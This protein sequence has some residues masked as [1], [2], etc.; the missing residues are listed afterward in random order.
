VLILAFRNHSVA[1]PFAGDAMRTPPEPP[2]SLPPSLVEVVF[3]LKQNC[4]A[5]EDLLREELQLGAAEFHC[6]RTLEDSNQSCASVAERLGLSPS[7][8]TRVVDALVERGLVTREPGPD[9]R[10]LSVVPTTAGRA[11]QLRIRRAQQDCDTRL[12]T[13]LGDTAYRSAVEAIAKV[14]AATADPGRVLV[15]A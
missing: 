2:T 6:L 10:T 1:Q 9:R 4:A 13:V 5:L 3:A 8:T 14:V 12:R 11:A 7:R 15:D